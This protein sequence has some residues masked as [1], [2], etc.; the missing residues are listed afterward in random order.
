MNKKRT[1]NLDFQIKPSAGN[2]EEELIKLFHYTNLVPKW[3]DE[4]TKEDLE[5]RK[6]FPEMYSKLRD[7]EFELHKVK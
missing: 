4:L 7:I 2:S 3:N 6:E 5:N 1:W